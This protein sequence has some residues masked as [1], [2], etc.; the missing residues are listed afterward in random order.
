MELLFLYQWFCLNIRLVLMKR[1]IFLYEISRIYSYSMKCV[2]VQT[3]F[4]LTPL[5]YFLVYE[6]LCKYAENLFLIY[7]NVVEKEGFFCVYVFDA[8]LIEAFK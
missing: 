7:T 8:I 1:N 3:V 2:I 5:K 4:F 6:S